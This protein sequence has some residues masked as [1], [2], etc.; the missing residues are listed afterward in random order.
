MMKGT[1]IVRVRYADTDQMK[2]VYNGKFFE[3][4]EVGRTELLRVH[5]LTYRQI[6]EQGYYMPVREVKIVYKNAALYDEELEI[7]TWAEQLPNPVMHL[8][9]RIRS[10]QRDLLICEGYIDLMFV[11][12]ESGRACRPPEFF[13]NSIRECYV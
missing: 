5:G 12:A 6:E 3:Y 2:F 7:E 9:H 11:R 1:T 10:V 13:I 4:F 8:Q